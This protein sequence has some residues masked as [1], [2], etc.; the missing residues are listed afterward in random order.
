MKAVVLLCSFLLLFAC[1]TSPDTES[2]AF[3][4]LRVDVVVDGNY[5]ID[6]EYVP[7]PVDANHIRIIVHAYNEVPICSEAL[8]IYDHDHVLF[9]QSKM[10]YDPCLAP[11]N[12]PD[13]DAW[14]I[15]YEIYRVQGLYPYG[16]HTAYLWIES[17][18]MESP[19]H[20]FDIFFGEMKEI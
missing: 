17:E 11:L 7:I 6:A 19:V 3:E 10:D 8:Q 1:A 14:T 13:T 20:A 18:N 16:K 12:D 15:G 4:I 5:Y 2:P 9:M